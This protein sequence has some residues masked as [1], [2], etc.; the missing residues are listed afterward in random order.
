MKTIKWGIIGCGNVCEVKSGPGFQKATNSELVA[1]MR[2]DAAL[3]QDYATRHNVP[4]W[5]SDANALIADPEVN[6]IYVAT[7]PA[8]HKEYCLL[9]AAAGKPV[10]VEK[11]MARNFA[12]CQAMLEACQAAG[13]PLFV[14]YYRRTL[15]RFVKVKEL[16]ETGAIGQVRFVALQMH[17]RPP[18]SGEKLPWR[19]VPEVSGGGLFV[20]LGSHA[21]DLLDFLFGPIKRVESTI[22]NQG[23]YYK[24]EDFVNLLFE[25]ESG[26]YGTST[27]CFSS[28]SQ[29]DQIEIN[30]SAGKLTFPLLQDEPIILSTASGRQQIEAANPPHV[31]QPLIQTVVNE[32]NGAGKSSSTGLSAARTNRIMDEVL[33]DYYS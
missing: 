3:A 26:V 30:G 18:A 32:L 14:A 16:L 15:P 24:A 23:D 4:R 6:A 22:A 33:A 2:R 17:R 31:Q 10:Y 27:W 29:L 13:V 9:A 20:D 28:Y 8:G 1:V 12:E 5:Y 7:P 21:L 19:V 11:P 25:H